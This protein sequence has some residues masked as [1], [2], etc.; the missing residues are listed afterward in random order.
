[1][2]ARLLLPVALCACLLSGCVKSGWGSPKSNT[3]PF[4]AVTPGMSEQRVVELL[5]PPSKRSQVAGEGLGGRRQT[6]L[7]WV[8][9][10]RLVT[11]TLINNAVVGKQ[12]I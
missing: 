3:D 7:R 2:T 1:M 6:V 8:G 4:T 10:N 5:G 9:S 11:V 12:K